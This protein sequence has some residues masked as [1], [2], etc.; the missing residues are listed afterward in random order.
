[1]RSHR[2]EKHG[3]DCGRSSRG[4]KDEESEEDEGN[5]DEARARRRKIGDGGDAVERMGR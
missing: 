2:R 4:R 1:M 5:G 3:V